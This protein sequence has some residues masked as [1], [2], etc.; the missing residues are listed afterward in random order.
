MKRALQMVDKECL[1]IIDESQHFKNRLRAKD[2]NLRKSFERLVE[3]VNKQ[4]AYMLL[5]T[6]TPY[7]KSPEDINNQ[8]YLLPHHAEREYV[9]TTGQQVFPTAEFNHLADVGAWKINL[10]NEGYFAKFQQLPVTTIISTAQVAKYFATST[11]EGD[12]VDF[13]GNKRWIPR[14]TIAKI[15]VPVVQ[16][17]SMLKALKRNYFKHRVMRFKNRNE[18]QYSVST[19]TKEARVS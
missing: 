11:E 5:L 18:W 1:I 7:T 8:L 12:Y 17:E 14:I 16:E 3:A 4:G 15:P 6:A 10:A 2:G 13:H 19:I 9:T